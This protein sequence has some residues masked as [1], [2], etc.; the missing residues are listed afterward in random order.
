[1]TLEK[2]IWKGY[3]GTASCSLKG[4]KKKTQHTES[5]WESISRLSKSGPVR[6]R[7]TLREK[8]YR[9]RKKELEDRIVALR[10]KKEQRN[11]RRNYDRFM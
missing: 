8:S 3:K 11:P 9:E 2:G 10:G 4:E 1:M 7:G 5:L 6:E